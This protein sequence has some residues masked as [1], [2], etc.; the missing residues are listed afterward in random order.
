[1]N[2]TA[3][4]SFTIY[5]PVDNQKLVVRFLFSKDYH[6][7]S[8]LQVEQY[9]NFYLALKVVQKTRLRGKHLRRVFLSTA[10][11]QLVK[12]FRR[13]DF[14][15]YIHER[16][17]GKKMRAITNVTYQRESMTNSIASAALH[18]MFVGNARLA[19]Y[20]VNNLRGVKNSDSVKH[21]RLYTQVN[22]LPYEPNLDD[23]ACLP[24]HK[25]MFID[26]AAACMPDCQEFDLI[27]S[28]IN[29]FNET[30]L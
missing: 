15:I 12:A 21:T 22:N 19:S 20:N 6:H 18:Y 2:V 3:A 25:R 23:F 9:Q 13:C 27:K 24:Q 29:Q 16:K 11:S 1:M 17:L 26:T 7:L 8:D 28:L 30:S 14:P 5:E 10:V 4:A